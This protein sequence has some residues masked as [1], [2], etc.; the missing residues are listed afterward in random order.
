METKGKVSVMGSEAVS[1]VEKGLILQCPYLRASTI[2][3]SAVHDN[4][5]SVN[6][7]KRIAQL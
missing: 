2:G 7:C 6:I 5:C 1:L 4:N 3:D